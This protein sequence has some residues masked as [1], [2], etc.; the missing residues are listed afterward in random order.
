MK[1]KIRHV[2]RVVISCPDT[3]TDAAA[4]AA[5]EVSKRQSRCSHM[6]SRKPW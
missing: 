6:K 4:L 1:K 3:D 5:A 2:R